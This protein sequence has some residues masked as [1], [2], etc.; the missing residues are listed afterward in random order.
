M[1]HPKLM[2]SGVGPGRSVGGGV[3]IGAPTLSAQTISSAQINITATYMGPALWD[4]YQYIIWY[5]TSSSG[6]WTPVYY[7]SSSSPVT[8][9]VLGLSANTNYY[10]YG[11]VETLSLQLSDASAQVSAITASSGGY[12]WNPGHYVQ[13]DVNQFGT[14][15]AT[16]NLAPT[17]ALMD[18][19]F[20]HQGVKG[21][22][23]FVYWAWLENPSTPG[24]YSGNWNMS[25][26]YGFRLIDAL[27]ARAASYSPP[28]QIMIHYRS[29]QPVGGSPASYTFPSGYMPS[30]LNSGTYVTTGAA[31]NSTTGII[32]GAFVSSNA[33]YTYGISY[34][35]FWDPAVM[36]RLI[37][38]AT[39]YA[40]RY[41]TNPRVE[42]TSWLDESTLQIYPGHGILG[43]EFNL[44]SSNCVNTLVGN[45]NYFQAIRAVWPNTQLRWWGNFY[46]AD[47]DADALTINNAA[48]ASK[49]A[50]G[51]P[52]MAPKTGV[53]PGWTDAQKVY[54][55]YNTSGVLVGGRTD[56]TG[57]AQHVAE[58]EPAECTLKNGSWPPA[59]VGSGVFATGPMAG[60]N[61][62][63]CTHICWCQNTGYPTAYPGGDNS[64]TYDAPHPNLLDYIDYSAGFHTGNNASL[65]S[66]T[67]PAITNLAYPPLWP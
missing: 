63:L 25:A 34:P 21:M 24:D 43:S 10:F 41:D 64:V 50:I 22:E 11:Q 15:V 66:V 61:Q 13:R 40:N 62:Y 8:V 37:A 29:Y 60:M 16:G 5:S 39:G 65:T 55:G 32:G 57:Q 67:A 52:D 14:D 51:G 56:Y 9:S 35:R 49:W 26:Y 23:F 42:M 2:D 3:T 54:T 30:Y 1:R 12:K 27:I 46:Y 20:A 59:Q 48:I 36:T 44:V 33:Y 4:L 58:I 7:V 38:L 28:R 19:C 45:G 17:Y 31:Q 18:Q 47:S 6:P 53:N